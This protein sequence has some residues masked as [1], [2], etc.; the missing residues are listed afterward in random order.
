M[1]YLAVLAGLSAS[2][3]AQECN[4]DEQYR[5]WSRPQFRHERVSLCDY[6]EE[7]IETAYSSKMRHYYNSIW[8][9]RRPETKIIVI[10]K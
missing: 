8:E 9:S 5:S 3:S 10:E 7:A 4:A 2:V 1:S 6:R